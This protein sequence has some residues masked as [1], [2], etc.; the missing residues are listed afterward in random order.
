[1]ELLDFINKYGNV[2]S[3]LGLL[4]SCFTLL[5]TGTVKGRVNSILKEQKSKREI[6]HY[7]SDFLNDLDEI[8]TYV[9][10]GRADKLF[11][12]DSFE[13][14]ENMYQCFV[15]NWNTLYSLDNHIINIWQKTQF[16][17]KWWRLKK[18]FREKIKEKDEKIEF[19]D[20]KYISYLLYLK[21]L[22][23]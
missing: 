16:Y 11:S 20:T 2:A 21:N 1:M 12:R 19:D 23:K 4:L 7:K 5:L 13:K 18:E 14:L 8:L 6:L 22:V 10:T 15:R 17:F 3:F 9:K